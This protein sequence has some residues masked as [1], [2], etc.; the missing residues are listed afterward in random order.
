MTTNQRKNIEADAWLEKSR[1][2]GTLD[3]SYAEDRAAYRRT[4]EWI[5]FSKKFRASKNNRCE[6]CNSKNKLSTHHKDPDHYDCLDEKN[7]SS[8][9]WLCHRKIET[10]SAT[11]D[12]APDV[13]KP[14]LAIGKEERKFRT[15][16]RVKAKA[17][18]ERFVLVPEKGLIV[19]MNKLRSKFKVTDP[20][21]IVGVA[22]IPKDKKLRKTTSKGLHLIEVKEGHD[23]IE[24]LEAVLEYEKTRL[25][26]KAKKAKLMVVKKKS[27]KKGI[28]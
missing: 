11:P 15:P 8:L 21:S 10:L 23:L 9:C 3:F 26:E 20:E 12:E 1:A 2:E 19:P 7:F 13:Y 14:H 24:D 28:S 16:P 27:A 18:K 5:S 4:T 6:I 17:S 22:S 25:L